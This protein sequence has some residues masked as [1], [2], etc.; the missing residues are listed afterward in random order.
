MT[1]LPVHPSTGLTALGLRRDGRP[2][3][4]VIGAADPPT[5][6]LPT[7]PPAVD[8]PK[9]DDGLTTDA[10]KKA[11]SEERTARKA[12]EK[13]K[14]ELAARLKE[15][16]DRDKTE[17]EKLTAARD[18]AEQRASAA[19]ARAVRSEVR[20][21]A[22]GYADRDDAVLNLGDLTKYVGKDGEVD[23]DAIT[24]ELAKVLERK[25]HL[26]KASGPRNPAPDPSQ[27]PRSTQPPDLDTQIAEANKAGDWKKVMSLQNQK[28]AA[29][30]AK[31]Q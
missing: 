18:A 20:A 4:P 10:G 16:E 21:L 23:T 24:A 25:P 15:F 1:S 7:D 6:P 11:L 26:A 19:T 8:P 17:A 27:G 13:E 3:W 2:I 12:A 9:P 31:Q 29:A 22:D 28:L 14:A 30:A 5:D